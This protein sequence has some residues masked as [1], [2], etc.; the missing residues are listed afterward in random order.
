MA[1]ATIY[2]VAAHAGVSIKS[3]SRVLNAE[4][5]VSQALR[6]KVDKA[7][8]ALG[9]RRSLSARTL[10]GA[11]SSLIA[12]L[13][14]AQ[15]TIEHWRSG[16][17]ND[18]LSRLELGA[19]MECR[20]ADFH[21][22]VELVDHGS[23]DLRRDLMSLLASIRPAGVML[24]PPNSDHPVV[25]DVLDEAGIPYA[26]IGP[27][28]DFH[29][30]IRVSMDEQQAAAD[31]TDHLIDLGHRRIGMITGPLGY[32]ASRLRLAGFE[33]A[34]KGRGLTIAP[35]M[36]VDGDFTFQSGL[37]GAERLLAAEPRVTAIFAANDDMALGVLQ[38]AAAMGLSVPGDLSVAGFDDTPSAL[39]STPSLTTIRQPVAEMAAAA[40]RRLVPSL[41]AALAQGEAAEAV[42]VPYALIVRASTGTP[43]AE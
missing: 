27:E 25:L 35:G 21:L 20:Q 14:D 41:R 32:S 19:L 9:Y 7:V 43:P 17:G 5:N 23:P 39:F 4:P 28:S 38:G 2:D 22:M 16:R 3:V 36:V 8:A 29:R 10:A 11:S 42:V 12:A 30:G 37:A 34:M 13:V 18:Y 40:T 33:A 1:T 15:L 24:T 6:D 31:I 26:R